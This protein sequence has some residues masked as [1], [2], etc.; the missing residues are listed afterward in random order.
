MNKYY[1]YFLYIEAKFNTLKHK[2][3]YIANVN[4][5]CSFHFQKTEKFLPSYETISFAI[6]STAQEFNWTEAII[7]ATGM[8]KCYCNFP[9][10]NNVKRQ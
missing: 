3:N 9:L 6:K 8:L 10:T 2:I 7:F 1:V 4:F 5:V